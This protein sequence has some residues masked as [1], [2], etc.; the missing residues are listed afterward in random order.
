MVDDLPRTGLTTRSRLHDPIG[1]QMREALGSRYAESWYGPFDEAAGRLLRPGVRVLDVG[2]GRLPTI[3]ADQRPAG[4]HYVALDISDAELRSSPD[5]SYDDFV[6]SSLGT[7]VPQLRERFDLVISWQVLEHVKPLAPALENARSYLVPGGH[8][9][10]MLSGRFSLPALAN[11]ALPRPLAAKLVA[12][13]M[14]RERET[15]FPAYYDG[16]YHSRLRE[17]LEPWS[18][19]RITPRYTGAAYLHFSRA[20]QSAYLRY[21]DWAARG[22]HANLATHYLIDATR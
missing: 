16:C 3:A 4:C 11:L 10:A 14:R 22:R 9:V 13:V 2:A 19:A 12:R 18:S 6:V 20:L 7:A 8:L 17:L 1:S 15:V 21:E 5:G